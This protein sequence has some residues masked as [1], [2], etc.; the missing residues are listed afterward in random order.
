MATVTTEPKP[1]EILAKAQQL[2]LVVVNDDLVTLSKA[3]LLKTKEITLSEEE[4]QVPKTYEFIGTVKGVQEIVG[5][6]GKVVPAGS[7]IELHFHDLA[8]LQSP[9][10]LA[11]MKNN[12]G[13]FLVSLQKPRIVTSSLVGFGLLECIR[14]A[15]GPDRDAIWEILPQEESDSSPPTHNIYL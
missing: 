7:F 3:F 1:E 15:N 4:S 13:A 14:Q 10:I 2:P 5:N 8:G 11:R 6:D 9:A 12:L